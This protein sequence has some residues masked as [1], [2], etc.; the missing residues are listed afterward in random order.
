MALALRPLTE[1]CLRTAA[2]LATQA[3]YPPYESVV[4]KIA[5]RAEIRAEYGRAQHDLCRTI[6]EN[7]GEPDKVVAAGKQIYSLGGFQALQANFRVLSS[8]YRGLDYDEGAEAASELESVFEHVTDEW[9][10]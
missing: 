2:A 5:E 9:R 7:S 8:V 4:A 1:T 10:R 3:P 6:Y